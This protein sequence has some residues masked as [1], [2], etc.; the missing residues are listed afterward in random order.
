MEP[1]KDFNIEKHVFLAAEFLV[2]GSNGHY[3]RREEVT[4]ALVA[5]LRRP[6]YDNEILDA[7]DHLRNYGLNIID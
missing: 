6:P 3:L 7:L 4:G 2:D 1:W 5:Q